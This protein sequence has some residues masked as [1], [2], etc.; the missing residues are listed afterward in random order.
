MLEILGMR[1]EDRRDEYRVDTVGKEMHT[2]FIDGNEFTDYGAFSFIREK[3][4]FDEPTRSADGV[5]SNLDNY[6]TFTTP[7]LTINFSLL[8]ID[9]YR[10]LMNLI[11]A[12]NEFRVTCYDIVRDERVTERMYFATEEMPKL[13]AL[14]RAYQGE[15]W[16]ELLGVQDY[17]VEMIGTNADV[18]NVK[19]NYYLNSPTGEGQIT[20]IYSEDVEYGLD[21]IVG[22]GSG[23]ESFVIEGYTFAQQW[24]LDSP[25]GTIYGNGSAYTVSNVDVATATINF[26][27]D[28]QT[29]GYIMSLNYGLG[30][31]VYDDTLT[32]IDKLIIP[33]EVIPQEGVTVGEVI[34]LANKRYIA[35]N[36]SVYDLKYLPK[37]PNVYAMPEDSNDEWYPYD[38]LG[39]YY[40]PV[41]GKN[42]KPLNNDTVIQAKGNITIYQ[43]IT[44]KKYRVTTILNGSQYLEPFDV[45]YKSDVTIPIVVVGG[46]I[47]RN[48]KWY[49]DE[50]FTKEFNYVMPARNITLYGKFV[51]EE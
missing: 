46:N 33:Q 26:Y 28:W 50:N 29:T 39:W 40:T 23:I 27:A 18:E 2:V 35:F 5:I 16:L 8:S 13:F 43:I 42:S 9:S 51:I 20:P 12:K 22:L 15:K 30:D 25:T 36:G 19:V 24:H 11:Y 49:Y 10:T 37:S 7:H 32:P 21:F 47:N 17:T 41:V 14:A 44:P 34:K 3:S 31:T 45:P 48:I 6:A 1:P 38:N 4:Y